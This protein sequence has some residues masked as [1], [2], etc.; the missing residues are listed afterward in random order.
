MKEADIREDLKATQK[1]LNDELRSV[2][3]EAD[4]SAEMRETKKEI[5]DSLKPSGKVS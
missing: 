1:D 5:K 4:I 2:R 3:K